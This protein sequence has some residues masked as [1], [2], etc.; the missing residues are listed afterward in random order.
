MSGTCKRCGKELENWRIDLM[1]DFCSDKCSME[2]SKER[3]D[4]DEQRILESGN[5][6]E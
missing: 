4:E 1:L 2:N 3:A 5:F 6:N